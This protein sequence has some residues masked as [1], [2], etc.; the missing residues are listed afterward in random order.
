MGVTILGRHFGRSREQVGRP[1]PEE[2]TEQRIK[3][4]KEF[5]KTETKEGTRQQVLTTYGRYYYD[6]VA[7][8][9]DDQN[10][11]L[12]AMNAAGYECQL[13]SQSYM[14]DTLFLFRKKVAL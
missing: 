11:L 14:R 4:L 8:G 2:L 7:G 5:V 1:T 3:G 9:L 10:E 13:I 6:G 12:D